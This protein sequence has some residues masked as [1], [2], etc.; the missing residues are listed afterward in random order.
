[1]VNRMDITS[2]EESEQQKWADLISSHIDQDMIKE[3]VRRFEELNEAPL[4]FDWHSEKIQEM[5]K[6]I[7]KQLP[8]YYGTKEI[9]KAFMTFNESVI[10]DIPESYIPQLERRPP[11]NPGPFFSPP[12][13]HETWI[14]PTLGIADLTD[15][16]DTVCHDIMGHHADFRNLARGILLGAGSPAAPI[17]YCYHVLDADIYQDWKSCKL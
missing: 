10:Q 2:L 8:I 9:P 7:G 16:S 6:R 17:F 3:Y 14:C 1:M 15:D 13:R 11:E 5:E 4:F 12:D